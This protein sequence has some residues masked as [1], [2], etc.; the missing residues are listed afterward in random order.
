MR[1]KKIL[2]KAAMI[3]FVVYMILLAMVLVFKYPTGMLDGTFRDIL[4]GN[5]VIRLKT[6]LIPFKTIVEY[7]GNAHA[8]NDWFVKNLVCNIVMFMPFGFLLPYFSKLKGWRLILS[9]LILS[10]IIEII[11]FVAALGQMDIDD[12]LL[13]TVGTA[14]GYGCFVIVT[15]ILT[16]KGS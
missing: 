6:Q 15:A 12:V 3:L 1:Q 11:Q 4:E 10:I 8:I 16:R 7:V 14:L 5:P 2:K 13:N 9:G